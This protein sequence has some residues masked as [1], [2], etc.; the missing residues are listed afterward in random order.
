MDPINTERLMAEALVKAQR[1]WDERHKAAEKKQPQWLIA[2][3]REAGANAAAIAHEIGAKLGFAVY[4]RELIQR[5]AEDKGLRVKLLETVDEKEHHWLRECI[6]SFSLTPSI[7]TSAYVRYLLETLHTLS[8]HG[9]CVII[10]RGAP[11]ILPPKTTFRVR[12][13]APLFERVRSMEGRLKVSH[14]EA[15]AWVKKTDHDRDRFV[16]EHFQKNSNDVNHYDLT[17]ETSRHSLADC[18]A[19]II[20][21]FESAQA[22]AQQ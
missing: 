14:D 9:K 4:G 3:S 21:A 10:G 17:L 16:A 13:H 1:H 2:I 7:S 15:Q 18:A 22:H 20:K 12:L 5:I 11:H 19:I 8:L 6:D